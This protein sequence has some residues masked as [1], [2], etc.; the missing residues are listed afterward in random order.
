MLNYGI[1]L[2]SGKGERFGNDVPKQFVKVAGKTLLEHTIEIFENSKF[3]DNIVVVIP[4][5]YRLLVNNIIGKHNYKKIFSILDGGVTRKDSSYIAI[6]S[7]T[8]NEANVIIHDCVRPF[9]SEKIIFDCIEALKKYN[10]VDVAIHTA[11]TI[12]NVNE[13]RII[14]DIPKRES[15]YRGQTPQC[16]KL[17]IIKKAH[18][19]SK[20]DNDFTDDCG[21]VL[22][23]KLSDIYVVEGDVENIKITY[24]SDIYMADRLFQLKKTL[25]PASEDLEKLKDVVIV[26]F[27]G[28]SG[29]GKCTYEL[30]SKYGAKVY[31]TSRSLGCDITNYNDVKK[32]LSDVYF[33]E[34]KI[35][36]VIN[37]AGILKIG[38]LESRSIDEIIND[39]K[40]NYIGTVNVA[41]NSI[42]YLK[43]TKGSIQLYTSSSYTRGRMLYSTYS[44]TKAAIVNL[45]QALAEE[46]YDDGIRVNAINPERCATPMRY[47]AF[48]NE[49]IGSLLNPEKVAEASLKVYLSNLTGQVIDV[50]KN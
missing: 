3:I 43:E 38:K 15:L 42:Q 40:I 17:S 34:K 23:H 4:S 44:S 21:V 39:I 12:I 41:K 32:Y 2:A 25:V 46:L 30:A 16:F 8:D 50:R 24:P 31:V 13:K 35:D 47:N 18:E 36:L 11:D 33:F 49:P 29:I 6:K 26:I 7:I 37:T 28:N 45:M 1:I 14:S 5:E 20:N 10:A 19:L 27:G 9:L 22:K 48:G